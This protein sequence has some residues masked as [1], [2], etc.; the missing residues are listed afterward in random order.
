VKLVD[1]SI[2]LAA[3]DPDDPKHGSAVALLT[4]D[5]SLATIDLALYEVTNV[6][7]RGWDDPEKAV[8]LRERIW[9]IAELGELVRADRRLLD[10]A[11]AL[12]AEHGLSGYDAAYVAAARRLGA[13]LVSCDVRDLVRPGLAVLP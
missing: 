5:E 10:D 4:S 7:D 13:T 1:A 9:A 3:A 2:L 11:A 12:V 8:R 6:A